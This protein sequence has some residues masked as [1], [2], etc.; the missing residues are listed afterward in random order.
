MGITGERFA[1]GFAGY[2]NGTIGQS[3]SAGTIPPFAS[4]SPAFAYNAGD[5]ATAGCYWDEDLTSATDDSGATPLGT[6]DFEFASNFLGWDFTSTW[7]YFIDDDPQRPRL[8]W[9]EDE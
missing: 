9:E 4:I 8:Q 3:Y 7:Q 2:N 1:G 5:G 6:D